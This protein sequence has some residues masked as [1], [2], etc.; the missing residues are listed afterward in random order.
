MDNQQIDQR[1]DNVGG[2]LAEIKTRYEE[3]CLIRGEDMKKYEDDRDKDTKEKEENRSN[4]KKE[5]TYRTDKLTDRMDNLIDRMDKMQ[6]SIDRILN[7]L[8][9]RERLKQEK[10]ARMQQVWDDGV[11]I[12][13]Y[14]VMYL[15]YYKG[16]CSGTVQSNMRLKVE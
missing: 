11:N 15:S 1:P 6:A 9:E 4:D 3:S 7:V 10:L 13:R 8:E 16:T 5:F 12:V 2:E 14:A